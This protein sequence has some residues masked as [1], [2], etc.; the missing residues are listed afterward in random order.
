MGMDYLR[1]ER[2]NR[3]ENGGLLSAY[4]KANTKSEQELAME[5]LKKKYNG[6]I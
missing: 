2:T 4:R 3:S 5:Y 1:S 6:S